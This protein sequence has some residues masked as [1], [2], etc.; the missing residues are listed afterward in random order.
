MRVAV[1]G[2]SGFVGRR[3]APVLVDAG[4]EVVAL[5]RRAESLPSGE[6]VE[7]VSFD[8]EADDV[9]AVLTGCQM[10]YYLVHSLDRGS[11]F[12]ER[13][14]VLAER[15]AQGAASAGVSRVVYVGGLGHAEQEL[16]EHLASRQEVGRALGSTGLDVVEL[17]AAVVLGAGSISFEML[18]YLTERLPVMVCPRWIRTRVQPIAVSDLLEYLLASLDATPGVYEIGGPDVTTYREMIA[19]YADARGLYRRRIIDVPLLTPSLSA[20][21]VDLVTP[22]N[23]AVSHA[24]IDSLTAEVV[25]HD[26]ERTKEAFGIEPIGMREAIRRALDDQAAALPASV[27][28]R[29]AGVD[30]GIHTMRSIAA[31]D[32]ADVPA[33]RA[34]LADCGGDLDWYGVA[35]LWRLRLLVG[36][37]LGEPHEVTKPDRLEVGAR[38][39]WWRVDV[40][41]RD[42]LV[43]T[44]EEWF[45]GEAW[46]GYRIMNGD[47]DLAGDGRG[48]GVGDGAVP[49]TAEAAE[50]PRISQVGAMRA[51]GVPGLVYWLALW[52][53]HVRVFHHMADRRALR[54]RRRR[55][56]GEQRPWWRK[57]PGVAD[58]GSAVATETASEPARW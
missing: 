21:W 12:R 34:E 26:A 50:G 28:D 39:D 58:T 25:V 4:H 10:A 45:F 17:R 36:R 18:R 41:G 43:L 30:N 23:Q 8:L 44:C 20:H 52:P 57:L 16:S 48:E 2:A 9:A 54:T 49:G 47:V 7:A 19:A 32:P 5:A 37:L 22:V 42:E 51:K 24:L 53:V 35:P 33:A 13:D 46:L 6:G 55:L 29:P 31:I 14:R 40:C 3:L 38:V 27:L 56:D 11:Q 15:F 1:V